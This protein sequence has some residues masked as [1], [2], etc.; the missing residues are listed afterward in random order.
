LT[1]SFS[2]S[3]TNTTL[4]LPVNMTDLSSHLVSFTSSTEESVTKWNEEKKEACQFNSCCKLNYFIQWRYFSI[5]KYRLSFHFWLYWLRW[6]FLFLFT[7]TSLIS[8][9]LIETKWQYLNH[10]Q[11]Q[12]RQTILLVVAAPR[13]G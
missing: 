7:Y 4:E 3:P 12:I 11:E 5:V 1:F 10:H 9:V 6:Y 2:T 8:I 13:G